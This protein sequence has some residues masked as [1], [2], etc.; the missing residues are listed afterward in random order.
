MPISRSSIRTRVIPGSTRPSAIAW[1]FKEHHYHKSIDRHG[2]VSNY[3][4]LTVN[5]YAAMSSAR[6]ISGY[7]GERAVDVFFDELKVKQ[8]S[9]TEPHTSQTGARGRALRPIEFI[10]K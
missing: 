2:N 1:L 6:Y 8:T 7:H 3:Y 4:R 5:G 10:A 9:E